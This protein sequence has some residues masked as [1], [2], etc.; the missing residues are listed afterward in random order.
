MASSPGVNLGQV[1]GDTLSLCDWCSKE[2]LSVT[3]DHWGLRQTWGMHSH[4][5]LGEQSVCVC[6]DSTS[7]VL[8]CLFLFSAP[9]PEGPASGPPIACA[10]L[11]LEL[12]RLSVW[13]PQ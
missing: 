7:P 5:P 13:L 4:F 2:K 9:A 6:R 1:A 12:L 3:R 11:T 8:F 10:L